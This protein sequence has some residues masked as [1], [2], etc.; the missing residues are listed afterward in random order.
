MGEVLQRF[1][2]AVLG[3]W[4]KKKKVQKTNCMLPDIGESLNFVQT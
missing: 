2:V 1:T 4:K 3:G